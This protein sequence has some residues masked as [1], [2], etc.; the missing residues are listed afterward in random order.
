VSIET[1]KSASRQAYAVSSVATS[2]TA[3]VLVATPLL[4]GVL[5]ALRFASL[6]PPSLAA[7]LVRT[8][9]AFFPLAVAW[10]ALG[11]LVATGVSRPE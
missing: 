10:V 8:N 5:V 2:L 11:R 4:T 9:L 3:R 6:F 7:A 1:R